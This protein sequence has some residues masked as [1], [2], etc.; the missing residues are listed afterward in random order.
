MS[1]SSGL[2]SVLGFSLVMVIAAHLIAWGY[3]RDNARQ[4]RLD[5]EREK[6]A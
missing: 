6:R 1:D 5:D 3:K 2:L 4:A